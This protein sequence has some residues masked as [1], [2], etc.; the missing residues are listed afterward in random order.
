M[1]EAAKLTAKLHDLVNKQD[2]AENLAD[3][4]WAK[5]K[6]YEAKDRMTQALEAKTACEEEAYRAKIYRLEIKEIEKMIDKMSIKHSVGLQK[7]EN[8]AMMKV[9]EP[10]S[11]NEE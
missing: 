9:E 2:W 8:Y 10:P 11:D 4:Y 7:G 6:G 1:K 5:A 3:R